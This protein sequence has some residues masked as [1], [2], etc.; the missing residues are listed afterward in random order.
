MY[1]PSSTMTIKSR[2]PRFKSYNYVHASS[3]MTIKSRQPR[4]KSYNYV[5]A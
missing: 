3:K 5:N 1:M 4:F 2:Q